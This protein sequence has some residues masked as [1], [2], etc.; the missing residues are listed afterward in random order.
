MLL[1]FGRISLLTKRIKHMTKIRTIII[2]SGLG[3][4]AGG[5]SLAEVRSLRTEI[6][7][8]NVAPGST[9]G[10]TETMM[11]SVNET[12]GTEF[13]ILNPSE[14]TE[15]NITEA[16][17]TATGGITIYGNVIYSDKPAG[18]TKA[19]HTGM[20]SFT[21]DGAITALND[22]SL[23]GCM[24]AVE[25]NGVYHNYYV[26]TSAITK[27]ST[28]YHKTYDITDWKQIKSKTITDATTPRALCT[29]GMNVYGC[30]I[31]DPE[32][33]NPE[34]YFAKVD[35]ETDTPVKIA[36]LNRL[37]NS[38]VCTGDG[39]VYAIDTAGDLLRVNV[40]TGE[41][42]RIG[43][44]GAVPAYVSGAAYDRK[45]GR[46]FWTVTPADKSGNLYEVD[47]NT[48]AATKLCQFEYNDEIAG[49]YI[50]FSAS[51]KAPAGAL[52]LSANFPDGGLTGALGFSCPSVTADSVAATGPLDYSVYIDSEKTASGKSEFGASV[53]VPVS[54]EKAGMYEFSVILSN[55]EGEG[56][57]T[58]LGPIFIGPDVPEAP[59]VSCAHADGSFNVSWKA[60]TQ[61]VNGGYIDQTTLVYDV[62]RLPDSVNVA[63]GVK[64]TQIADKMVMPEKMTVYRYAVQA[65][66]NNLSSEWGISEPV[67]LGAIQ[68]PYSNGFDKEGDLDGFTII[69]ANGDGTRFFMNNGEV[70][71][72]SMGGK[73]PMDD[74]LITPPVALSAGKLYRF[75]IDAHNG[76]SSSKEQLEIKMGTAPTAAAMTTSVC[77]TVLLDGNKTVKTAEAYVS[78]P[79]TGKYYFGIHGVSQKNGFFLYVD[80]L[81]IGAPKD[82]S[83]A[84]PVENL[85]IQVNMDC[86][87]EA[88]I[89]GK[90]PAKDMEDGEIRDFSGIEIKRGAER[91]AM[92]TDVAPGGS[93]SFTDT[94]MPAAGEYIYTVFAVNAAGTSTGETI[95][96][97]VGLN[98]PER[99]EDPE[100]VLT[101]AGGLQMEWKAPVYDIDGKKM[102][103]GSWTY[104]ILDASDPQNSPV[105]AKDLKT[106]EYTYNYS[107]TQK[108]FIPGIF[109][110]NEAGN[111]LG[112]KGSVNAI[113]K[114]Y[115]LPYEESFA[116]GKASSI[117]ANMALDGS[118][119]ATWSVMK[120][121][122]TDV[123]AADG[124]GGFLV[125]RMQKVNQTSLLFTG[126]ISLKGAEK[127]AFSFMTYNLFAIAD[128]VAKRDINEINVMVREMGAD[129]WTSLLHGTVDEL[130][131]GD[132]AVWG[133]VSVDLSPYKGKEVQ[134]GLKVKCKYFANTLFDAFSLKDTLSQGLSHITDDGWQLVTG[135]G[136]LM[137]TGAGD[138]PVMISDMSG[139]V[140]CNVNGD[141][142]L[143]LLPGVYLVKIGNESQK[144]MIK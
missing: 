4:L 101:S 131:K 27:K 99:V 34:V 29:D 60:V 59:E 64:G 127:P 92:L 110:T 106:P 93:F 13:T 61:G 54:V 105:I 20:V 50:P 52:S 2:A 79:E 130:C 128:G 91:I 86:K 31:N 40:A 142:R 97:Y 8:P 42:I 12:S 43:A 22:K 113:G 47:L 6:A 135:P 123:K 141:I 122:S 46:M 10:A 73:A 118:D 51:D 36:G 112:V 80:N 90:A 3:I 19:A 32:G 120:E 83:V 38:C 35:I 56:P 82:M 5:W 143:D 103:E 30:Y 65:R 33:D 49:L 57:K 23:G 15:G 69:D 102:P 78:V 94:T 48:G 21:P 68:P 81:T 96:A 136:F 95:S 14:P 129:S 70:R 39:N 117:F 116:D 100:C 76:S 72:N 132:T 17:R 11:R 98:K 58:T 84:R 9:K 139:R 77:D 28:Y 137:V 75:A 55:A 63:Q 138:S 89:S 16:I 111:S 126:R 119:A 71:I 121:S 125:C 134:M 109:A 85:A 7:D 66:W 41:Q 107:G 45:S 1:S 124:D 104:F 140:L 108:F 87:L 133:K 18:S 88:T 25:L 74:W 62:M 37:W 53:R 115:G 114:A 26:F 144:I 24:A 67:V 44:T